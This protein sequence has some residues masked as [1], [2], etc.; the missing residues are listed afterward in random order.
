MSARFAVMARTKKSVLLALTAA[1]LALAGGCT[2]GLK[3]ASPA[4]SILAVLEDSNAQLDRFVLENGMVCLLKADHSA[5]VVS[6]QVWV[7]TGSIHEEEHLGSGLSHAI[8]HM[9]FKGTET[10]ALGEITKEINQAGGKINAYTS[11]DRT[12]FHTDLPARNWLVGLRVLADAVMHASFP[13]EEWQKERKVVL[14]EFAMGRDDPNRVLSKLLRRTAYVVHPYKFPVIGYEDVFKSITREDLVD[15]FEK[16]YV[17]DNMIVV[18]VGDVDGSEAKTAIR[19]VFADFQRR[20]RASVV[21]PREPDQLSPRFARQTGAY[22][23]SRLD[24]SYHTVPMS[25]ADTPALDLLADIVGHGRSSRLVRKIKEEQRLVHSI[26]AW[27]YTPK[28]AGLFA[29]TATFDPKKENRALSAIEDE[30]SSWLR[31]RFSRKEIMKARRM[32]LSSELSDLQTMKGQ[33]NSY[34]TGEFYAGNPRFSET[35]LM[36]LHEVTPE[37]LR[38]VARRYLRPE[39]RTLVVLSPSRAEEGRTARKTEAAAGEVEKILLPNG[40]PLLVREDHRLPFVYFCVA[41]RGGLL[42]ENDSNNGITKVMSSLLTR[43]TETRSSEEIALAVESLGGQLSAFSGYN[44]FGLQA[45][46]LTEDREIFMEIITDCLT[47]PVFDEAE[48]SKHKAL[49]LARID[50]KHEQPFFIAETALRQVL[51]PNHPYRWNPLGQ[52]ETVA[53]IARDDLIKHFSRHAVSGNMVIA[54]FGDIT[55]PEAHSMASRHLASI[56]SGSLPPH[57]H[58][59]PKPELPARTKRREPKQQ[60][61]LLAGFPGTDVKDPRREPLRILDTIMS[62]LSSDFSIEVR[63]KR[64]LAY[65]VGTYQQIGIEPGVYVV[66]AGTREDTVG[67]VELLIRE[68]IDRIT[69]GAIRKE[70]IDRAR[71]QI[72][73]EYEM[74][75]QDNSGLAMTCALDELYGL[76]HSHVFSTQERFQSV[77]AEDVRR[78][79]ASVLSPG[80]MAISLVLP[81]K[82]E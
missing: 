52:K 74:R 13:E 16:N 26:S 31:P 46:C 50:E 27:S 42:S 69:T 56:R 5:P 18:V 15:F 19:N 20:G 36:Q 44:S 70:E 40:T 58:K 51:F 41:L 6:V 81:E 12:V 71:N 66:Y 1:C 17:P 64:G 33:A 77:T 22:N 35:Y 38:T 62:G 61:I 11:L 82:K 68:E 55:V 75:L 54:I 59:R 14:R 79:A 37:D 67:E 53:N 73:A 8:E 21:L 24:L 63:E 32:A 65:Y 9:I 43:G 23:V 28:H 7:G 48:V 29:I 10:R 60:A 2:T 47:N 39:N 49:Q 80:K 72:V 4:T 25:H 45:R 76:G 34:A 30:V 78:A 3:P 57:T